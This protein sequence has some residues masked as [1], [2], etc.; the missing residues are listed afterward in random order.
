M[1][2]SAS[3]KGTIRIV[4]TDDV[5][6]TESE[7]LDGEVTIDITDGSASLVASATDGHGGSFDADD[8]FEA[9]RPVADSPAHPLA[10]ASRYAALAALPAAT[11]LVGI[12]VAAAVGPA[13]WS[14]ASSPLPEVAVRIGHVSWFAT[15]LA[16]SLWLWHDADE[17]SEGGGPW[18]PDPVAY[19]VAGALVFALVGTGYFAAQG[20]PPARLARGVLGM[21]LV[22]L[23]M[24]SIV[25]GPV[26]LF[27][28]YRHLGGFSG[29]EGG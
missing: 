17:R 2:A 24:S 18:S 23:P 27:E 22:G 25:A 29:T 16:G 5:Y 4:D 10:N 13:V 19:S 11:T 7:Q 14:V 3:S 12:G 20:H 9:D 1:T 21:L 15:G 26:Y 6:V 8:G 28:R